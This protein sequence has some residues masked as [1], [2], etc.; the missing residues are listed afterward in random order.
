MAIAVAARSAGMTMETILADAPKHDDARDAVARLLAL[1]ESIARRARDC[2][3]T[4]E[5]VK[6][7]AVS[8]TFSAD[9]VWPTIAS[10]GQT[11]FGENRV[12]EAIPKWL[13][14]RARAGDLGKTIELHLIGPLQSNKAREAVEAFDV[15][16]TVDR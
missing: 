14:L 11:R 6:L 8:K 4:P 2:G 1:R 13:D 9:E 5:S 16:E 15:I 7:V 12:Q 10:A 3:R